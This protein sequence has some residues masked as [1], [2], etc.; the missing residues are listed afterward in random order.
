MN[1]IQQ[2]T[3]IN[4]EDFLLDIYFYKQNLVNSTIDEEKKFWQDKIIEAEEM[5]ADFCSTKNNNSNSN[6]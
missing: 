2:Q 6:L 5:Y 1:E 3:A 4:K